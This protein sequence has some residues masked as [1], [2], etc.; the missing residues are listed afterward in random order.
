MPFKLFSTPP[1]FLFC[2]LASSAHITAEFIP[3]ITPVPGQP[4][5]SGINGISTS[6]SPDGKFFATAIPQGIRVF[7]VA[8]DGALTVTQGSPFYSGYAIG[9]LAYSPNGD[10]LTAISNTTDLVTFSVNKITGALTHIGAPITID[11]SSPQKIAYS[12]NG[13]FL[14]S[15]NTDSSPTQASIVI[16]VINSDGTLGTQTYYALDADYNGISISY[17]PDGKFLAISEYNNQADIQTIKNI[18]FNSATGILDTANTQSISYSSPISSNITYAPSGEYIAEGFIDGARLYKVNRK[19]G[20][21]TLQSTSI[22]PNEAAGFA[23][24]FSPDSNFLVA[25]NSL[26]TKIYV[27]QISA[28]GQLI[29]YGNPLIASQPASSLSFSPLFTA[30]NAYFSW[31]NIT[32]ISDL[33]GKISSYTFNLSP[34]MGPLASA[35]RNKYLFNK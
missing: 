10:F 25:A 31:T 20:I 30:G 9:D 26:G 29:Q 8:L 14:A 18:P 12:P 22:L 24:T 21:L 3:S 34:A 1:L 35:I 15:I 16:F 4:F 7:S 27:L 17:A 19:T 28:D 11:D 5:S 2:I 13:K 6:Y 32:G 23:V 33:E